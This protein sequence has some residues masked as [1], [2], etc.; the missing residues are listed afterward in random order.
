MGDN[1]RWFKVWNSIL[2]DPSFMDL[3]LEQLGRWVLLGALLCLHGENGKITL[4][5]DSLYSLLRVKN[6]NGLVIPNTV[7]E[8]CVEDNGKLTVTMKN[9]SKYQLDSTGY[10]RLK[11]F[12]NSRNDNGLREE[13][14][15]EEKTKTKT[16]KNTLV[17]TQEQYFEKCKSELPKI[18]ESNR[19]TLKK[20]YPGIDL[21]I[22]TAKALAWLFANPKNKK[23]NLSRFLNNWFG[24]NQERSYPKPTGE[25]RGTYRPN[26]KQGSGISPSAE[27]EIERINEEWRRARAA[28][29]QSTTGNP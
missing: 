26:F 12:R 24:S 2:T 7:F 20:A 11:K 16:K 25:Y 5:K 17:E 28:K 9:W 23:K 14:R 13:K 21:D 15:R 19:E 6:D 22:Q 27:A 8:E 4:S 29:G 3:P 1:K 10:E 18:L